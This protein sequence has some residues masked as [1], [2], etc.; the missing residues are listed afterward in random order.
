MQT[1]TPSIS[2]SNAALVRNI[3]QSPELLKEAMDLSTYF[4]R[5]RVR[6]L[7]FARDMCEPT[8]VTSADLDRTVESDQP[9]IILE[10]D[11]EA[12][13][14]TLPFRGQGESKYWEGEKVLVTFQKIE[15]DRFNKSKFEMMN[16]KTDYKTLL[17]KRI[18]EE[19]FKVE[20]ETYVKGLDAVIAGAEAEAPGTQYQEVTGGL[21]KTNIKILTQMLSRLKMMPTGKGPKPKILMTQTLKMELVELGMLEIGDAGV[22]K[23]W[24]EG[25]VGVS[26]LFGIPIVDTIKNEVV[27][28]DVMYLVAPQ[29]YFSR[30]FILQDHTM[31]IKTEADMINFYSYG[32]FAM[33]FVN[34]K[35]VVKIKLT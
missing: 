9:A 29:D 11:M 1:E 34:T 14:M 22:S 24:N 12:K 5:D 35:G 8:F 18:V 13:A 3:Y 30:F 28:D 2:Q 27:A 31:V 10:K 25:S 33:A 15:S 6:E 7:G 4:V 26:T 21:N 20:D 16:S 19:M 32:S 17:E 23:F